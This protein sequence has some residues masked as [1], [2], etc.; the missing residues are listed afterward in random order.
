MAPAD[1]FGARSGLGSTVGIV[2]TAT[3]LAT[4]LVDLHPARSGVTLASRLLAVAHGAAST[5]ELDVPM[6]AALLEETEI[7]LCTVPLRDE[8]GAALDAVA[9]TSEM[10]CDLL[11]VAEARHWA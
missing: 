6:L 8:N 4:H 2:R 11:L 5:Q 9:V 3:S 10:L 1:S 7:L